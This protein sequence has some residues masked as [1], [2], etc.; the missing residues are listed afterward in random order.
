MTPSSALFDPADPQCWIAHGR[1]LDHAAEL[2]AAWAAFPDLPPDAPLDARMVRTRERAAVLRPL[3]DR[4]SAEGER[5]RCRRNFAFIERRV[6][7]G[8]ADVRD[9]AILDGRDQHG[10]DWDRAVR[11]SEGWYA[12]WAGWQPRDYSCRQDRI[13]SNGLSPAY[14]QGFRDG[15]GIL[16]DPFDAARRAYAAAARMENHAR[17]PPPRGTPRP[18]PSHLPRPT[19]APRPSRWSRR[20]LILGAG[21]AANDPAGL[22]AMLR[23]EPG[24]DAVTIIVAATG[25]G[26]YRWGCVASTGSA[27]PT[28]S[29][30]ALLREIEVDDL[31]VIA[32]GEDMAWIDR[33]AALLPLCRTMERTRNSAIQ[34]RAQFRLWLARGFDKEVP[35]SGHIRWSKRA[36][37]LSGRLGEF[38]I[39]YA[40][41]AQPRGHRIVVDLTSGSPATGYMTAGGEGLQP[42]AV[43]GN[44]AHLRQHMAVLLRR[45]AAAIPQH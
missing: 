7:E 34:Q 17:A 28:K 35:A 25:R 14:A 22:I 24:H 3:H 36:K 43:I 27:A 29:L 45:F 31:L 19:D 18:L 6:A 32:E 16:D 13:Q 2:A 41:P 44:K 33:H 26:F 15:G 9:R 39:R 5:E 11:Y 40:G 30:S 10:H 12:T 37:G 38:V 8:Q 20:V 1:S 23:G 4:I 42:E 21:V